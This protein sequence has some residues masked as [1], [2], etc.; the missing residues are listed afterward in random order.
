MRTMDDVMLE[1]FAAFSREWEWGCVRRLASE[2]YG[3]DCYLPKI[4]HAQNFKL[5]TF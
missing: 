1:T 2:Y 4:S 3:K 5:G